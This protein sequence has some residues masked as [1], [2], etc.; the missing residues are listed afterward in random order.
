MAKKRSIRMR[1]SHQRIEALSTLCREML[2]EF[3]P[4]DDHQLL[5]R[6]HLAELHDKLRSMQARSQER[7]TLILM[8]TEITAFHQLWNLLGICDDEYV[9]MVVDN[10]LKKMGSMAA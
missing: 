2:H 5:L 8:G 3:A 6:E 1:V 10:L 7:Y 4:A 9:L